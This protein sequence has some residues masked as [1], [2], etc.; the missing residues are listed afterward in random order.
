MN[1]F[2][3]NTAVVFGYV[4]VWG[5][6]WFL[7]LIIKD[8]FTIPFT[9]LTIMDILRVLFWFAVWIVVCFIPF[10]FII[11]KVDKLNE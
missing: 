4:I 10:G 5:G 2:T 9:E 1:S 6:L 3:K 8:V 11:D 7:F